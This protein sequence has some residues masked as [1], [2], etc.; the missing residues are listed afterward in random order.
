MTEGLQGQGL[1]SDVRRIVDR[2]FEDMFE[3][4]DRLRGVEPADI[5]AD[6]KASG[7][8]D[9]ADQY[10]DW[11][12][13]D[14]PKDPERAADGGVVPDPGGADSYRGLSE[15]LSAMEALRKESGE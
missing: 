3:A 8:Y 9:V 12:G 4:F 13:D 1:H 10:E 15:H 7:E 2:A 11:L 5:L 6:L 14:A